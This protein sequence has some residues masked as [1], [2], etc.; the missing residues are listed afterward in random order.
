MN[1][2]I[3]QAEDVFD[4]LIDDNCIHGYPDQVY[5]SEENVLL[6][7][8]REKPQDDCHPDMFVIFCCIGNRCVDNPDE[9]DA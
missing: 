5:H 4:S 7:L 1:G 2:E 9:A 3:K 6:H 8:L